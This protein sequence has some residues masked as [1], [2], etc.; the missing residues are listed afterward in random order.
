MSDHLD[1]LKR[2]QAWRTGDD[3]RDM[4]EAGIDPNITT[5]AIDAAIAEIEIARAQQAEAGHA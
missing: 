2:L 5:Q 1:Y 3:G 4:M